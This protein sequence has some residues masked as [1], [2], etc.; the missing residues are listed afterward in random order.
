MSNKKV[1]ILV[2]G[3]AG[4]IGSHLVDKLVSLDYEVIVVDDLSLGNPNYV[5][6]EA[7]FARL[8]IRKLGEIKWHFRNVDYVFHCAAHPRIQPSFIDPDSSFSNNM[9][10][11]H[12]VLLAAKEAGVKKVIYSASSSAY[13]DQRISPLV[14]TLTP[15]P[16]NPYALHKLMGEQ[17]CLKFT[18]WYDLPTV[19]LRYFNVYGERQ[20]TEGAYATVLGVFLKQKA[21][22]LPLTIVGDGEQRRDFTHVTDVVEANI[23]AMYS[24]EARRGE[25]VNIGSGVNYSV[26][27]V[28]DFIGGGDSINKTYLPSR[29][30]ESRETLAD[31]SR[32]RNLLAF[33]PTVALSDWIKFQLSKTAT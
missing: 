9:L 5:N 22:H 17:L 19:C 2:T 20:P 27:E 3:G 23:L 28:A 11:T 13:G 21:E 15:N 7:D 32:A 24:A 6:K 10:G 1:K 18:E 31:I 30:G 33:Q 14:E 26:N 4:F 25:V 29:Q 12:N 16:K 8:D